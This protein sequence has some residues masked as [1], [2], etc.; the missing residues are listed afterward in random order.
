MIWIN[1]MWGLVNLLPIYPLDGG[2]ATQVLLS[3]VDRR[4]GVRWGHTIS[5]IAAGILT[6]LAATLLRG[7]YYP[8]I[9]FGLL[10]VM[11]YQILQSLHHAQSFGV[12][13]DD[14]WWRN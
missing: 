3:Q 5:L 13:H 6:V 8:T 7:D 11:N 2:Q 10:A 9:F 4:S 14:D 1:L 12:Y